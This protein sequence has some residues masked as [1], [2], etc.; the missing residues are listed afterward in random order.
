VSGGI[1]DPQAEGKKK[2]KKE[3]CYRCGSNGHLFFECTTVL[4][5]YCEQVGHKPDDCHLLSAPKP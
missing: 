3:S 5:E 4:C 2:A 1:I